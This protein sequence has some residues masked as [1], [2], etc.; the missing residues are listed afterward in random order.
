M[1]LLER[2]GRWGYPEPMTPSDEFKKGP[3]PGRDYSQDDILEA[4]ELL[5]RLGDIIYQRW[6]YDKVRSYR[7]RK[8]KDI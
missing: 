2:P 6:V 7:I 1:N 3:G 4:F 5:N 8:R